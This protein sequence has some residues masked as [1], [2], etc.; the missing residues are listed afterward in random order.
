M[1]SNRRI[2]I[3]LSV[4]AIMYIIASCGIIE[5]ASIVFIRLISTFLNFVTFLS[6]IIVLCVIKWAFGFIKQFNANVFICSCF[7]I[8]CFLFFVSYIVIGINSVF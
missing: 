5:N 2:N 4:F 1:K 7:V 3:M 8:S 6:S